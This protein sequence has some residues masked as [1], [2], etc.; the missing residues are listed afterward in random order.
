MVGF[1]HHTFIK[2]KDFTPEAEVT[3]DQTNV[4][5]LVTSFGFKAT[6]DFLLFGFLIFRL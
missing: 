4:A 2:T 6:K 1:L 5:I 3:S